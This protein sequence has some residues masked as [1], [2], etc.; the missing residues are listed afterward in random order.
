MNSP[1]SG[2]AGPTPF[3]PTIEGFI[4]V[5]LTI[6]QQAYVPRTNVDTPIKPVLSV[7]HTPTMVS[8]MTVPTIFPS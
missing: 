3:T 4:M 7:I 1:L 5:L 6:I 8:Q 2:K